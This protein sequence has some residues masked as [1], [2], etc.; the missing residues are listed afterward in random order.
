MAGRQRRLQASKVRRDDEYFTLIG[1]VAAEVPEYADQLRG[2]RVCCPCDWIGERRWDFA[3]A[4]EPVGVDFPSGVGC[5]FVRFLLAHGSEY[6]LSGLSVSGYSPFT[7]EG[8]RFQDADYSGCDV[9]ITNPPFS[10]FRD[11]MG[12]VVGNGLDFLVVGP[13][14]AITYRD[15]FPLVRDGRVRLGHHRHLTGFERPDGTILGRGDNLPRSCCW[16]TSLE[17]PRGDTLVPTSRYDPDRYPR[18]DNY[19]AIEVGRT[20]DVPADYDG[21]MGVPI[22]FLQR[23]DPDRFEIVML[24]NGN[25][26]TNT[27]P[28]TLERASYVPTPGDRGGLGLV[29][30]RRVYARLIVRNR[31]P[32]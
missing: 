5:G 11:F 10:E 1:D 4:P 31:R 14:N 16:W 18:Y 28:E 13:Q 17:V 9:V 21:L 29:G 19:D 24:A 22:T 3:T 12:T 2:R 32:A 8:V 27:D 23:Y 30:G 26:R 15:F 25:A 7:G 6:G 20:S